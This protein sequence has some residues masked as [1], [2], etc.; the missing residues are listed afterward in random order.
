MHELLMTH[1]LLE[2]VLQHA[3]RSCASR[4]TDVYVVV[5]EVSGA[6]DECMQSYW[7]IIGVGTP[8]EGAALHFRRVPMKLACP[9]CEHVFLPVGD[10]Y[11]CVR[12]GGSRARLTTGDELYV[13]AIDVDE[14]AG[15]A[16]NQGNFPELRAER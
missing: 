15:A 3:G 5:G 9:D 8:A 13:E 6:S 1:R 16:D 4:V 12:C 10:D 7:D 11:N 2:I 14:P